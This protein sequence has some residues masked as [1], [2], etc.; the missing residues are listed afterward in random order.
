[1]RMRTQ[2]H[3]HWHSTSSLI[4]TCGMHWHRVHARTAMHPP[5]RLVAHSQKGCRHLPRNSIPVCACMHVQTGPQAS[6]SGG[7]CAP[8]CACTSQPFPQPT[9]QEPMARSR[10]MDHR[11]GAPLLIHHSLLIIIFPP[12]S[13]H[14]LKH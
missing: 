1:M 13:M 3:A 2:G 8:T 4:H 10:A 5:Q 12:T 14:T 7:E 6:T 11:L 9:G